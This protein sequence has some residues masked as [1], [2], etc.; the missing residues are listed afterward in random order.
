[1]RIREARN[2]LLAK[3]QAALQRAAER[4]KKRRRPLEEK[5]RAV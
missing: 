5:S 2:R 3:K 4:T 1:M